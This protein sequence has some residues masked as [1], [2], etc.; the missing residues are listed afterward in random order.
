MGARPTVWLTTKSEMKFSITYFIFL[1]SLFLEGKKTSSTNQVAAYRVWKMFHIFISLFFF[2]F[3]KVSK[4]QCTNRMLLGPWTWCTLTGS[5][6]SWFFL[7]FLTKTRQ[8]QAPQSHV[9][10]VKLSP[11]ALN[12]GYEFVPLVHFLGHPV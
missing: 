2:Y 11:T 7:S 1:T 4:Q 5:I 6:T 3:Y 9:H 12:V 8:H 10:G